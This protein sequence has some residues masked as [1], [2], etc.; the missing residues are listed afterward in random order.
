MGRRST[1]GT[2]ARIEKRRSWRL[3]GVS[4]R[5]VRQ[6]IPGDTGVGGVPVIDAKAL[7]SV[8]EV[9][10]H[11]VSQ[12]TAEV[13][14]KILEAWA[15]RTRNLWPVKTGFSRSQLGLRWVQ[16]ADELHGIL[17]D[18]APYATDIV[19]KDRTPKNV[20]ERLIIKPSAQVARDIEREL[21]TQVGD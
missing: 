2:R 7:G 9:E 16:A 3:S 18:R 14:G 21:A 19:Q 12:R 17:E 13:M 8:A 10:V 20:V 4:A 6:R 15:R 1:L 5:R 11:R